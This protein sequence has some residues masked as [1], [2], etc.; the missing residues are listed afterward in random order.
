MPQ[1]PATVHD[2]QGQVVTVDSI[3]RIVSLSGDVTEI[4][5][6]LGLGEHVVGV[7]SS[8][9]YPPAQTQALPNIGYQRRLS[10]EGVLS[11]NPSLVLGDETAGPPEV[12]SQIRATGVP[13]VLVADPP[14]LASP[15]AKVR[16]VAA[17]LGVPQRGEALAT[18]V[19]ATIAAA[20]ATTL[21]QDAPPRVLF[22]Y[23][24]GTDVQ[25]VA[26]RENPADAMIVAAGAI[27]AAAE[28]GIVEFKPLSPE[29]IIAIQPD[30]IL[31]LEKGL[32]SIGGV[33]GLLRIP[34]IAATP[35]GRAQHI[36]A[37]DDLY[38]LGLGPRTGHALADLI[39][40]LQTITTAEAAE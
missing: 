19:A 6:A 12:L 26:G 37:F 31:V 4:I 39:A 38:L 40:A 23:L 3:E 29:V 18:Q 20:K 36:V 27:N 14:T 22:L 35:A 10:A 32:E 17:A 8:A 25:Q 11:L 34:G 24:R 21:Q 7:D 9:T 5:F 16:W 13:V 28:A 30:V 15:A 33:D 1:L 2:Y